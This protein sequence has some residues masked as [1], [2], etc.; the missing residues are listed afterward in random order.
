MAAAALL[1]GAAAAAGCGLGPGDEE[2]AVELTVSRDRGAEVMH[3]VSDEIAE[4]D[5]VLRVL[6]RNAD[7]ETRYGG[8]FVQSIDGVSG[9][10][11]D[12]RRSDWFY[13]VNGIE[14]PVGS[15]DYEPSDGDSVWWDHHDWSTAMRSPAVVGSWPE[16]FVHGFEGEP[17]V[18]A[19]ACRAPD[20]VCR[21]VEDSLA[22]AGVPDPVGGPL[23]ED[24]E[25]TARVMVGTWDEL[26]SDPE[27]RLLGRGP[28]RSG[29]FATF[30]GSSPSAGLTLLDERGRV[31]ETLGAGAGL[32]AAL[33]PGQRPPTLVVTGTDAAGVAAAAELL[34][35]ELE[36]HF[37][38]AALEN[39]G[40]I[41]VP[42]P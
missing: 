37:A 36:N 21:S 13:Y 39:A 42:V 4:S 19:V 34:G 26:R 17:Y 25:R 20:A 33:R 22:A 40:T 5:T 31:R 38:L 8:G 23:P 10:S 27:V 41:P 11:E 28:D 16:P 3:D 2:G 35:D 6:D 18:T 30:S 9:G 14:A 7:V 29:V 12:G 15:A 1:F 24:F 32:V